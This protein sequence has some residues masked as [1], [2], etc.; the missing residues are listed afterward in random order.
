MAHSETGSNEDNNNAGKRE[1]IWDNENSDFTV[2]SYPFSRFPLLRH[3]AH[4]FYVIVNSVPKLQ[5]NITPPQ[6]SLNR[7][8]LDI[9]HLMQWIMHRWHRPQ[10]FQNIALDYRKGLRGDRIRDDFDVR[11]N[12]KPQ[13]KLRRPEGKPTGQSKQKTNG[14][15]CDAD[16]AGMAAKRKRIS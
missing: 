7:Q 13:G 5:A 15:D 10:Q 12:G 11:V 16:G 1:Q 4:P 9:L 2:Y 14:T 6:C 3:H 8:L